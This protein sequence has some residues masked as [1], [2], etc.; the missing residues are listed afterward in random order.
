MGYLTAAVVAESRY[1]PGT[2]LEGLRKTTKNLGQDNQ[3]SC[4]SRGEKYNPTTNEWTQIPDMC[5]RRT[6]FGIAVIDDKIFAIGGLSEFKA[7]CDVEYYD[8]ESN[9]WFKARDMNGVR[10]NLSPCVIT[11]LPNVGDDI[12]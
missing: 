7:I 3:C 8:R 12:N 2:G 1:Y 4:T 5:K 9:T 11:G 10:A 6:R